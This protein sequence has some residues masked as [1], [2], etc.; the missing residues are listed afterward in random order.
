ML[1]EEQ[2]DP[3]ALGAKWVARGTG[4]GLSHAAR[5]AGRHE[6]IGCSASISQTRTGR[7]CGGALPPFPTTPKYPP[8]LNRLE[9]FLSK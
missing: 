9:T 1:S 6:D 2:I 3:L 7:R 8:P 4:D 5:K